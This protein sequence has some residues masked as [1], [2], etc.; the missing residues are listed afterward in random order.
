M[1]QAESQW[2]V[3]VRRPGAIAVVDQSAPAVGVV[4]DVRDEWRLRCRAS[5]VDAD[6]FQK[7]GGV[8]SRTR[9]ASIW[10]GG[11]RRTVECI[12]LRAA[13]KCG[14]EQWRRGP[15][16][17][18]LV[19]G[20][21]LSLCP[22]QV[23]L[24]V[25]GFVKSGD[26]V[27]A[28]IGHDARR[29]ADRIDT[30]AEVERHIVRLSFAVDNLVVKNLSQRARIGVGG[31]GALNEQPRGPAQCIVFGAEIVSSGVP[32]ADG[33]AGNVVQAPSLAGLRARL[34][35]VTTEHVVVIGHDLTADGVRDRA[36][37]SL[38]VEFDARRVF[39]GR[40][41]VCDGEE[42]AAERVEVADGRRFGVGSGFGGCVLLL[43]AEAS[44]NALGIPGR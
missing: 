28:H 4:I 40:A 16:G 3:V 17:E 33:L 1:G 27:G 42:G 10:C 7:I 36:L 31:I 38:D 30:S 41:V 18:S 14:A 23:A 2:I 39:S 9:N 11:G 12:V 5:Q 24:E 25:V 13:G 22:Q 29:V 35:N 37:Q 19:I 21:Q 32:G 44:A 43:R 6:G 26:R 8:V 15:I 34:M 20:D